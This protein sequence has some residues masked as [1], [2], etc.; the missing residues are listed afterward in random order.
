MKILSEKAVCTDN[1]AGTIDILTG[2]E[3]FEVK[4]LEYDDEFHA[5]YLNGELIPS[6]TQLLDKGE[7]D[8]VDKKI[9]EYAQ[10]KGTI[11]HAEV[12]NWLKTQ[13]E[14]FTSEL[15]EFIRLF[16]EHNKLFKEKAIFDVKTYAVASPQNRKKCYEQVSMY[17]NA[18]KWQTN[19][20][21]EHLYL[22][23]LP[24]GKE[25]KIYDLKKE[26]EK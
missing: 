19:E 2:F 10:D 16:A 23:H 11:V 1:Y 24:H 15:D 9:L 5:Y 13:E 3:D 6:V 25:G 22:I 20:E 7:Y 8:E 18:V 4:G 26:F 17:A 21:V 12:E 14:G